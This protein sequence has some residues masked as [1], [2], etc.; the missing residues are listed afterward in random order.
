M[1]SN[2][3][4]RCCPQCGYEMSP[5]QWINVNACPKCGER[6][7]NDEEAMQSA[8]TVQVSREDLVMVLGMAALTVGDGWG[9]EHTDAFG[10]LVA[11]EEDDEPR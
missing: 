5:F 9:T 4:I 2:E 1:V 8:D 6:H 11:L 3:P 7:Y 10:R